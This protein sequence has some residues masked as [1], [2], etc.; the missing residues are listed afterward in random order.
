MIG[1]SKKKVKVS[2]FIKQR[3]FL[4]ALILPVLFLF[5]WQW[6][7]DAGYVRP[8]LIPSPKIVWATFIS[9][10]K[11]GRLQKGLLISFRRVALGFLIGSISG[12]VIGF[13]MGLFP[14]INKLFSGFISI[15]RPIPTI[16]LR[17]E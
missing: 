7:V 17:L 14:I 2:P 16:A 5:F 11:N 13:L 10:V 8:T 1:Y 6:V 12:S 15:L 9:L 4:L 3:N